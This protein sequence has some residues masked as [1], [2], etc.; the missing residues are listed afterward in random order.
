[1]TSIFSLSYLHEEKEWHKLNWFHKKL[2][3]IDYMLQAMEKNYENVESLIKLL[4]THIN[5]EVK[6]KI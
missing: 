1:M 5:L 3:K 2:L 4:K 6:T